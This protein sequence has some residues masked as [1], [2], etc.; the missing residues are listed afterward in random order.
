MEE[1]TTVK[2]PVPEEECDLVM[3]GGVTSG[4]VYPTALWEISKRYRLRNVGGAS[5]GAIAAVGA[6]ACEYRRR[7]DPAAFDRLRNLSEEIVEEGFVRGLF[8]PKKETRLAFDIGLQLVSSPEPYSRRVVRA[9]GNVVRRRTRSLVQGIIF[10]VVWAAAVSAAALALAGVG[11]TGLGIVGLVLLAVLALA[12]IGLLVVALALRGFALDVNRALLQEGFGLCR[13]A[14]EDGYPEDSGLTDWLHKTIQSCAG[15][16]ADDPPLTFRDL[17]GRDPEDPL[18]SLRL[19][20]TDLSRSRPVVLPLPPSDPDEPPYLFEQTEFDRLFPPAVVGYLVDGST[21]RGRTSEGKPL[22]E[23]PGLDLPVVVAARLSLS[24]P[25]LMET[26]PLWRKDGPDGELVCH[27]MSD[28]GIS[29]NF[30]IHFFD[31]L[32]PGRPTFGLDLQPLRASA[33]RV[34][35]SRGPRRPLFDTVSDLATFGTQIVNAARNWRDNM[36]AELPGYRDRVCQ[37]RLAKDEG[38]LNLEMNREVVERLI[39]TGHAAGRLVVGHSS[40]EWWDVHRLTRYRMLMQMLQGTLG[41]KGVGRDCVYQVGQG[42][43]CGGRVPFRERLAACAK[44]TSTLPDVDA[45]WCRRALPAS[46]VVIGVAAL[47]GKG[48]AMDFDDAA[49]KPAPTMRIVPMA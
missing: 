8:Q 6:A 45:A 26:V 30:P 39:G 38:G 20:T 36:Q 42:T 16:N 34:E 14:S 3:R 43:E 19:V 5:A 18:V 4:A 22:Y 11:P 46:D 29:S 35:M 47:L 17:Q 23:L 32:L 25:V 12:G 7:E 44:G 2:G 27:T 40:A 9:V 15:R 21:P 49:L 33:E 48:G 1:L 28:G 37:I 41:R 31:A 10:V 24:F 13:G